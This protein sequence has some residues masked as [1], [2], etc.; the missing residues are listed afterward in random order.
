M[1]E[2]IDEALKKNLGNIVR[3]EMTVEEALIEV[4]ARAKGLVM[5]AKKY[6]AGRPKVCVLAN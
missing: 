6:L 4:K 5:F 3:I 2:R 1:G